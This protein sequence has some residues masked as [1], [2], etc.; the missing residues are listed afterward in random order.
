MKQKL[1]KNKFNNPNKINLEKASDRIRG[2]VSTQTTRRNTM[3]TLPTEN[4]LL[5][6][7]SH[8]KTL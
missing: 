7:H 4:N 2:M 3:N 5:T 6:Y 1:K 8:L